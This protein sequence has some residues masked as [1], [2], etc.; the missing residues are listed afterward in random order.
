MAWLWQACRAAIID[1]NLAGTRLC[2]QI[3]LGRGGSS[4]TRV[5]SG[6]GFNKEFLV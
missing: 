6:E 5:I 2:L 1:G 3:K 4:S